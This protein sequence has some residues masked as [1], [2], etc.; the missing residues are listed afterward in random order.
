MAKRMGSGARGAVD[1]MDGAM[2]NAGPRGLRAERTE[3][4]RVGTGGNWL[5][6]AL[7]MTPWIDE[8]DLID[9]PSMF[10]VGGRASGDG[11]G[12]V[13]GECEACM[14]K[15]SEHAERTIELASDRSTIG[16]FAGG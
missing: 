14:V 3:S 7:A 11:A 9:S 2:L 16:A 4:A 15:A 10:G 1:E 5:E 13:V 6:M 8:P 12:G